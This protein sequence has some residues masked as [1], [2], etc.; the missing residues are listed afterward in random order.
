VL[1]HHH[2]HGVVDRVGRATPDGIPIAAA[3]S[4][5]CMNRLR[6]NIAMR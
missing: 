6:R 3:I 2:R 4:P 1:R 5:E